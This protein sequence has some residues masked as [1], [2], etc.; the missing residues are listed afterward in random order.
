MGQGQE[1]HRKEVELPRL[2]AVGEQGLD[3]RAQLLHLRR[4]LQRRAE[5]GG[6][7]DLTAQAEPQVSQQRLLLC[8][9]FGLDDDRGRL[10]P[11]DGGRFP[12]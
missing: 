12:T 6:H 11:K 5:L 10:P 8:A 7:A 4:L 2:E 1:S 9:K 3:D